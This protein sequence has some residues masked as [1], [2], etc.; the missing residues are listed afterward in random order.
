MYELSNREQEMI[1]GGSS[2]GIAYIIYVLLGAAAYKIIRSK[3]GRL[4]LPR[5]ISLEW[6]S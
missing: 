5:L 4:S 6:D 3:K 1:V 2:S